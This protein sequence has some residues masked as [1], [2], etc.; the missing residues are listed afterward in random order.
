MLL[1]INK[2][3]ASG[4]TPLHQVVIKGDIDFAKILIDRG[5]KVNTKDYAQWTPL[6]EACNHGDGPLLFPR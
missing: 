3:N 6:H 4:E 1:N 5:A 2:R